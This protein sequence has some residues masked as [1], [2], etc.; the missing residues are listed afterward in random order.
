M[1]QTQE[2]GKKPYFGSDLDL[3]GPILGCEIFFS[4]NLALSV[5]R[6]HGQLSSCT[7]SEKTNYPI[8]RKHSDRRTDRRTDGRE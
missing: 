7:I 5:T 8:L 6:Y 1:I 4:K 3:L 2:N